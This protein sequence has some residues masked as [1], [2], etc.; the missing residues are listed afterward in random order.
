[1]N[2]IALPGE[3]PA[4]TLARIDRLP[5]AARLMGTPEVQRLL[6]LVRKEHHAARREGKA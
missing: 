2:P 1:V 4:D 3:R 5:D 6:E